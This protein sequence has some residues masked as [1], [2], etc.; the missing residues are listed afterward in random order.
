MELVN[1]QWEKRNL[2]EVAWHA[3]LI[4][5]KPA[6]LKM[7]VQPAKIHLFL[8]I[9]NAFVHHLSPYTKIDAFFVMKDN[10]VKLVLE[11]IS[12][13]NVSLHLLFKLEGVSVLKIRT[14]SII[15]VF[16]V[17]LQTV[18]FVRKMIFAKHA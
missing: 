13:N 5:V 14:F 17:T 2:M 1:A 6:K 7:F 18:L 8:K 16:N 3:K 12:V 4:I 9:I 15:L 11:L 10:I